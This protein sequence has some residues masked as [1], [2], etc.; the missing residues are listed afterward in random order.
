LPAGGSLLDI[1]AGPG[2]LGAAVAGHFG[3]VAGVEADASLPPPPGVYHRWISGTADPAAVW[4]RPFDVIVFADVLEHLEDPESML[5][6]ARRWLAPGG[7]LLV[8]LPNVA[9]IAVRLSLLAGRF[10]Y[11]DRGILD[12]TH[13]RF[14]TRR[15]ARRAVEAAGF[16]IA[17]VRATPVPAELALPAFG[18]RPWNGAVRALAAGAA[19]LRPTLFGYQFVFFAHPE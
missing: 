14:F 2:H 7:L 19:R 17:R 5:L 1:G 6:A 9:N 15:S 4:E 16:R 12:R 18:R 3:Y 10:E 8:S 13:L 11:A